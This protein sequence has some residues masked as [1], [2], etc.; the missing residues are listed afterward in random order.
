MSDK[1]QT[2]HMYVHTYSTAYQTD[3]LKFKTKRHKSQ[4]GAQTTI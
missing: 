2:A 3:L 1:S 4:D